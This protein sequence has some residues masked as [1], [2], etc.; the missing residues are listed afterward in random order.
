MKIQEETFKITGALVI[1]KY[2]ASGNQNFESEVKNMVVT[3]GKQLI[4]SRLFSDTTGP[5]Q[6]GPV[7]QMAIGEG[8]LTPNL[9]DVALQTQT[10]IVNLYPGYPTLDVADTNAKVVY[11]ASFPAGTGTSETVGISE[12]G[13]FNSSAAMLCRTSFPRVIKLAGETLEIFWTVTIN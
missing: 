6:N 2:D 10:G 1:K 9:T 8:V 3:K 4:A 7:T 12:A 11:V 5:L 13:L